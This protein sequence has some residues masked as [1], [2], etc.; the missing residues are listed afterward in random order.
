MKHRTS[1]DN[2][3]LVK[4]YRCKIT[5]DHHI[6]MYDTSTTRDLHILRLVDEALPTDDVVRRSGDIIFTRVSDLWIVNHN[7]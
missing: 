7:N 2:A 5:P 6:V 4:L 3:V 1:T